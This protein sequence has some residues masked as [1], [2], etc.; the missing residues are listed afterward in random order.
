LAEG[1][2]ALEGLVLALKFEIVPIAEARSAAVKTVLGLAGDQEQTPRFGERQGTQ[3]HTI[4]DC[5]NGRVRSNAERQR[6]NGY[7]REAWAVAQSAEGVAQ[8]LSDCFE[9]D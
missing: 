6:Q 7:G 2:D 9:G 1:G 3:Q 8:I 4:H 5:E